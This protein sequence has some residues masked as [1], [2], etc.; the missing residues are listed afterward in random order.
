MSWRKFRIREEVR[1][2]KAINVGAGKMAPQLG[3]VS[4]QLLEMTQAQFPAPL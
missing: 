4:L 1:R 3:T 2:V